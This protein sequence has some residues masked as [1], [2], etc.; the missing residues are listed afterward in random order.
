MKFLAI[1][2]VSLLLLS[3]I[4]AAGT[5]TTGLAERF[6]RANGEALP[7][8]ITLENRL[9][10]ASMQDQLLDSKL[11]LSGVHAPLMDSL[12]ARAS[13]SQG[14]VLRSLEILKSTGLAKDAHTFWIANMI[15]TQ[16]TRA[17]AEL[18]ANMAEVREVGLDEEVVLSAAVSAAPAETPSG[19]QSNLEA[20]KAPDAWSLGFR[21]ENH[22]VC[23]IADGVNAEHPALTLHWKGRNAPLEQSWMGAANPSNC[24][25]QGTAIAGLICGDAVG[26]APGAQWIGAKTICGT[27]R[28]SD[29][30]AALEWAADPDG[31]SHSF[32]DVPDAICSAWSLNTACIG[33]APSTMWDVIDNVQALGPVMIFAAGESEKGGM[34]TVISPA[35][36]RPN[37]AVGNADATGASVVAHSTSARGP[38]PCDGAVKP[39]LVAPGTAVISSVGS[40]YARVTGTF[41]AAAQVAGTVTLMRQ[42]NGNLSAQEIDRMLTV[43]STDLGAPHEDNFTGHGLLNVRAAVEMAQT[44]RGSGMIIVS[45]SYGGE[46][47]GGARVVLAGE[48]G[49][50]TGTTNGVGVCQFDHVVT[51]RPYHVSVSRFGFLPYVHPKELIPTDQ[52]SAQVLINLQRG[53]IDDAERDQGWSLGVDGDNAT[54]GIW[55]RAIPVGTRVNG[56]LAEPS[57]DNTP[58]GQ[59]CFV[60]GVASSPDA[61]P[62]ASDVDGGHTTLRSPLFDLTELTNPL[63]KF[64]YDYSNELGSNPGSDFFRTQ[65]SNDGG[66]TWTNLINTAASTH[67][68]KT[69]SVKVADFL[70]P[71]KDMMLQFIA[72]DDGPGSLVEAAVDDIS[73]T[74]VPS[75]PEPPSELLLS[76]QFD[77]AVLI[78]KSSPDAT[79][80]RVYLSNHAHDVVKPENL[81]T[82]V[83]D[84]TLT[85]PLSDIPYG[86]FYF[87]VTAVK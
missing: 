53:F 87:Q 42:A 19:I 74:G 29:V 5:I 86:E 31:N 49:E 43:S 37:L 60:T 82:T 30:I 48:Y 6:D 79:K 46:P 1:L 15:A 39:D 64:A 4:S 35:S 11:S 50:I 72:E 83:S 21:G 62:N 84:T 7:V 73:I 55:E 16:L 81:F 59:Y 3:S 28:F 23:I 78:W 26:V 18:I 51:G 33:A 44:A 70:P 32:G 9:N 54:S 13:E 25:E 8:L 38:S 34:G 67:G 20:I 36:R 56:V 22:T 27:G 57:E 66:T 61:E 77:Q 85:V 52:S 69:V 47:I 75:V 65:I 10:A 68:W 80:Y 63:L 58:D 2:L 41:A 76:V 24:G 17:G 45:V 14:S 12:R 71:T 40:G